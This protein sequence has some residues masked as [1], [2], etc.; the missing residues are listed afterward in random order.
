MLD[1]GLPLEAEILKVGHHGSRYSSSEVFL[2]AVDPQEAIISVGKNAHGHPNWEVLLRLAN[3]WAGVW[4]T[5]RV[6]T[7]VVTTTGVTYTVALES[8]EVFLPLVM[9]VAQ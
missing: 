7:I 9:V 8:L 6:G 4:R 1:S 2:E 3:V 5:D